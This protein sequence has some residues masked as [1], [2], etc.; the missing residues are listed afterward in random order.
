[1][2]RFENERRRANRSTARMVGFLALLLLAFAV[3]WVVWA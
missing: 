2:N 3:A 1:M